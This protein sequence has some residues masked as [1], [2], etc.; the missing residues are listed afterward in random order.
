MFR[1]TGLNKY[2]AVR[3]AKWRRFEHPHSFKGINP[4]YLNYP[5]EDRFEEYAT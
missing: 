4:S 2:T 1:R 3:N 5:E